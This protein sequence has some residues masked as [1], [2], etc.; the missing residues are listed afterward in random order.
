MCELPQATKPGRGGQLLVF[1]WVT[2]QR[3]KKF[4]V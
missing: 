3:Q 1:L 4:G 2:R